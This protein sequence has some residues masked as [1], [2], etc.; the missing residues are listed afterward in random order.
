M[1]ILP[2]NKA[3]GRDPYSLS[4]RLSAIA[5]GLAGRGV[6]CDVGSDHG[7]LPLYLL[8]HGVCRRAIVTDVS[9]QPLDRARKALSDAGLE[10]KAT[11]LLTDGIRDVVPLSPDVFVIAGMGG[12]TIAG[13][14]S[15]AADRLLIGSAFILQPMTKAVFLRRFLYENG[16]EVTGER[17]VAENGKVFLIFC[18][19]YDGVIRRRDDAFYRTGGFLSLQRGEDVRRYWTLR[20]KQT[21]AIIAGKRRAGKDVSSELEEEACY[22]AR[23]EDCHEDP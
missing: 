9:P 15:R 19:R 4:A 21:R 20:L 8:S 6:V 7:A 1:P 22:L 18:A 2:E 14:L 12:M 16:F 11:F 23:L 13:I 5:E 17:A 3:T 10:E